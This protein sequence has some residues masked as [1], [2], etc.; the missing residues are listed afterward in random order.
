M[1]WQFRKSKTFGPLRL[2]LTKRGIS[3]SIGAGPLRFG[4]NSK[5]QIRRTV[6]VPGV[7]LYNT[8]VIGNLRGRKPSLPQASRLPQAPEPPEELGHD[9]FLDALLR[10]DIGFTDVEETFGLAVRVGQMARQG[11]DFTQLTTMVNTARPDLTVDQA[12]LFMLFAL[13]VYSP[14]DYARMAAGMGDVS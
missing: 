8:E 4:L 2:T 13:R 9:D 1:A 12:R 7:G 3:G 5:G 14:G 11:W 10:Y 6:R